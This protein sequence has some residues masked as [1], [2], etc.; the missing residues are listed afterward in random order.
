MKKKLMGIVMAAAL[1]AAQ[2]VS[3]FAAPSP[4]AEVTPVGDS[5]GKYTLEQF[6]EDKLEELRR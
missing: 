6:V 2:T 3:V 5:E 4:T 1:I